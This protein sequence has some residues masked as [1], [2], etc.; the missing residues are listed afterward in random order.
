MP[1]ITRQQI[2][3]AIDSFALTAGSGADAWQPGV[4]RQL[5]EEAVQG[6]LEMFNSI[7]QQVLWPPQLL[8]V[9]IAMIPKEVGERPIALLPLLVRLW[10]RCRKAHGRAWCQAKHGPW[11]DVVAGSSAVRAALLRA[12]ADEDA[13]AMD[14]AH[15]TLFWDVEKFYD[16]SDICK[17]G[18]HALRLGFQPVL[19][20]LALQT[21]VGPRSIKGEC[22]SQLIHPATSVLA[23][24]GQAN[25][26]ARALV[27]FVLEKANSSPCVQVRQFVD[28]MP[29]RAQGTRFSVA[30]DLSR[31]ATSFGAA[32]RELNL[33][34]SPKSTLVVSHPA[35]SKAV[36]NG[37][38]I[39]F[40]LKIK[41]AASTRDLGLD[42]GWGLRQ[43]SGHAPEEGY[44]GYI[45]GEA[46]HCGCEAWWPR[47]SGAQA[48]MRSFL[49]VW[50]PGVRST[51]YQNEEHSG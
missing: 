14:Q 51:S 44:Q 2:K 42:A 19:L 38:V 40:G 20:A 17:L 30:R 41:V 23:G 34:T 3:G 48:G 49:H 45:E 8:L 15:G 1:S 22:Y 11:D 5:S 27:Y 35:I 18:R 16:S 47:S 33:V 24:C 13:V 10:Q 36:Y 25:N 4:L 29:Q 50:E 46:C 21:Y 26:M 7:E 6:L 31:G 37:L 43:G 12:F 32:L 28:D 9:I 39:K